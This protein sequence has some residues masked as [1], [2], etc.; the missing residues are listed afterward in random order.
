MVK[1]EIPVLFYRYKMELTELDA[2]IKTR[3]DYR[4][5]LLAQRLKFLG[6]FLE[7]THKF[8]AMGLFEPD[9]EQQKV[10]KECAGQLIATVAVLEDTKILGHLNGVRQLDEQ[11][12]LDF[13]VIRAA[14]QGLI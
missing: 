9:T 8:A 10:M 1:E 5:L 14:L 2:F 3:P 7:T 12:Y 4:H 13:V 11:L 6:H